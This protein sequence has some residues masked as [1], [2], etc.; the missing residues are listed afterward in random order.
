M[1]KP[2]KNDRSTGAKQSPESDE[3]Y[4]APSK[5]FEGH[6]LKPAKKL[7]SPARTNESSSSMLTIQARVVDFKKRVSTDKNNDD[8]DYGDDKEKKFSGSAGTAVRPSQSEQEVLDAMI[9]D[10]SHKRRDD[11]VEDNAVYARG[12]RLKPAKN[13]RQERRKSGNEDNDIADNKKGKGRSVD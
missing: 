2:S 12:S 4:F 5:T 3:S 7:R 6:S 10:L 1:D 13:L 8:T 11:P 9:E